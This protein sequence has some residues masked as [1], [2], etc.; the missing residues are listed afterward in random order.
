MKLRYTQWKDVKAFL[1]SF[2]EPLSEEFTMTIRTLWD[3][4]K[5]EWTFEVELPIEEAI[6]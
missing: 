1:C 5:R 4:K 2:D 6:R 3:H